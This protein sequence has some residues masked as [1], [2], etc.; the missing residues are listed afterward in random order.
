MIARL[1]R[2]QTHLRHA[3]ARLH[4]DELPESDGAH[5]G[6]AFLF[7]FV[8]GALLDDP[9]Y[10][11]YVYLHEQ[12]PAGF[13]AFSTDYQAVYK[14]GARRHFP[15]LSW[16][17]TKAVLQQPER[18]KLL[19]KISRFAS[20]MD[21]EA[22]AEIPTEILSTAVAKP[23]RTLAFF[24]RTGVRIANA[25]YSNTARVLLDE[26]VTQLKGFTR[27]SNV[28][29]NATISHLGWKKVFEGTHPRGRGEEQTC[30]W[31]WDLKEA[32]KRLDLSRAT[33]QP[34]PLGAATMDRA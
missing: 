2:D 1:T 9:R 10:H 6:Q 24:Q 14:R 18:L 22:Y 29:V 28:L 33:A 8:Y 32:E 21:K 11:C 15:L 26:G 16:V 20:A 5:L 17:L 4:R 30:I 3:V 27:K 12:E 19:L 13:T 7:H 25:L 31:L 23:F 34:M